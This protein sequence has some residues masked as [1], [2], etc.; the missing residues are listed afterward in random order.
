[1]PTFLI[2]RLI[3]I[4]AIAV[5]VLGSPRNVA[6]QDSK[7]TPHVFEAKTPEI[8]ISTFYLAA[9]KKDLG[10]L[11]S[12][13]PQPDWATPEELAKLGNLVVGFRIVARSQM[14][15]GEG[16]RAGDVYVRTEE[17]FSATDKPGTTHFQLR[18]VGNKWII[19]N[20]NV[21]EN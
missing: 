9:A 8:A 7:A 19:I 20:F 3:L 6:A 16:V 15:K 11:K 1:M 5:V 14:K 12:V 13:D 17:Y 21:D 10:L 4:A 18:K 2:A